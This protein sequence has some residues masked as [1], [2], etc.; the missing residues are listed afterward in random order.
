MIHEPELVIL[1]EPFSGLDPVNRDLMRDV[2]LQVRREDKTVI[3]STHLMEQPEQLCDFVALIN[4]GQK[5]VDGPLGQVLAS[6]GRAAVLDYDGDGHLLPDLPGVTRVND[7][8]KRAELFLAEDADWQALLAEL[9]PKVQIRGFALRTA[10]LHEIFIRAIGEADVAVGGWY[11]RQ[12]QT[13][14]HDHGALGLGD[15]RPAV[16]FLPKPNLHVHVPMLDGVYVDREESPVFVADPPLSDQALQQIV[17][18]SAHRT[19]RLCTK[20][21]LLYR[22]R[23]R[24]AR[25][26]GAR[27]GGSPRGF[28]AR[29][30]RHQSPYGSAPTTRPERSGHRGAYGAFVLRVAFRCMRRRGSSA[31]SCT[32]RLG[33]ATAAALCP[34]NRPPGVRRG[35]PSM[36][37]QAPGLIRIRADRQPNFL[38]ARSKD[39]QTVLRK[40]PTLAV[41]SAP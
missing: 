7:S 28:G 8:G 24:F 38:Q 15:F 11:R 23:S 36:L 35:V 41:H 3:F 26:R 4:K 5:V 14:D 19:I 10:S 2:I 30:H 25:R 12:A 31:A 37:P 33:W 1:D 27:A 40:L 16:Q 22:H 6:G 9:V 32:H 29:A 18:T 39:R 34:P 20:R 17:E 21:G 13:M